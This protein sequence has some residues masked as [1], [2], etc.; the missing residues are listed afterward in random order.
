MELMGENKFPYKEILFIYSPLTL[1]DP[2][3]SA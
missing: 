3:S 2:L 1:V